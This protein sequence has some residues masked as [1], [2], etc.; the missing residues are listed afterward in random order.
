MRCYDA[1]I[2]EVVP[3]IFDN[4]KETLLKKSEGFYREILSSAFL[5]QQ[6]DNFIADSINKLQRIIDNYSEKY[7]S[8][9][10]T[11]NPD[12]TVSPFNR[13]TP[14]ID[15][16]VFLGA[17]AYYL[18]KLM[19]YN[20]PIPAG[21]VLTTEVFR[22]METVLD[23][24]Y[25]SLEL[26][27]LINK[28]LREIEGI[29]KQ[30]FGDES[31]P[32]L[33]SVRSGTAISLPG[34]MSTFLNVGINDK[35]A[36]NLAK[37]P[38][39]AWM[40]WDSYRRF[41]QS[42]GMFNGIERSAFDKQMKKLKEKYNVIKKASFTSS[43]MKELVDK[44][45]EVLLEYQVNINDDPYIQLKQAINKVLDSWNTERAI[46]YR[47]HLQI[48]DE[49]GTAVIIQKMVMGNKSKKSGSGVV[50]TH[51]PKLSKPGVNL[52]G[53]FTL[54]SQGED[55]V[56]GLVHTLP[57]SENQ[58]KEDYQDSEISLKSAFPKIYK[59]L[60]EIS[61]DLIY[62][63]GF[64]N[65]EI[66]FTFESEEPEDL[67]I[68]QTR[69]Q[70]I[71]AKERISYFNAP[72]EDMKLIG[73][74]IG[75][76]GGCLT[77]KVCFDMEDLNLYK[78]ESPEHNLILVRPD[79]VPDDIPKIFICDGLVTSRGGVT[80]HSA[81]TAGKLGKVC[82]VN[83][84]DLLIDDTAKKCIINEVSLEPGDII[85][86]DGKSGNIFWGSYPI[87]YM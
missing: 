62:N 74:G 44:Y 48:A 55:I 47:K 41:I 46:S 54:C 56:A 51:N 49:W 85:S 24:P 11:Y 2:G 39:K 58:R 27:E 32:L 25:M 72:P 12:L 52:Y 60:K 84:R 1:A 20:F 77:G 40:A 67:Y 79:T 31:N 68:L 17:K 13:A 63:Y 8:N 23:H 26:E 9:M 42:W 5:I 35:I 4:T 83:C 81:V 37:D 70:I 3:R 73:R 61:W 86:I 76:D 65:Q 38:E 80:S 53:D 66:E 75:T 6:L 43:Q 45:K 19:S 22:H 28:N 87:D 59:R 78:K 29:T 34:G 36:N 10:M 82:I 64:S 7:I 15:N 33:L 50:F 21:F 16:R 71:N 18:K 14:R 57:I 30:K 69:E